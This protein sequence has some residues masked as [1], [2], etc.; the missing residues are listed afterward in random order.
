L[1][2]NRFIAQAN[3]IGVTDIPF[4]L[5]QTLVAQHSHDLLCRTSGLGKSTTGGL[6]QS[7]R[8]TLVR[9]PG[10]PDCVTHEAAE[11]INCERL[12][13]RRHQN[14]FETMRG[15]IERL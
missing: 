14:G 15:R 10:G 9:Q 11:A 4:G 7:M 8:L 2:R 1:F 5:S 13:V 12:T 3:F 6:P